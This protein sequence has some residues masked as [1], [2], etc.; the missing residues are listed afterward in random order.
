MNLETYLETLDLQTL[1]VVLS[2]CGVMLSTHLMQL[3]WH[4]PEE[5]GL[6]LRLLRRGNLGLVAFGM[7]WSLSYATDRHWQP[8]PPALLINMGVDA[9]MMI[10]ILVI[11]S[12]RGRDAHVQPPYLI[13]PHRR[14]HREHP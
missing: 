13:H 3:A 1:H 4:N 11:R 12:M 8:W 7:L 2:I 5:G 10:R 14:H 6:L 9:M